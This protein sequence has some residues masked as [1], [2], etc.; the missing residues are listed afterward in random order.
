MPGMLSS[1]MA[2][3]HDTMIDPPM[4]AEEVVVEEDP[5]AEAQAAADAAVDAKG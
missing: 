4:P 1:L 5:D 3:D 2:L